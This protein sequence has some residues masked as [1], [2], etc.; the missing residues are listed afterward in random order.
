[1]FSLP[2]WLHN[3]CLLFGYMLPELL[4]FLGLQPDS[5]VPLLFGSLYALVFTGITVILPKTIGKAVFTCG[6][7]SMTAWAAAQVIYYNLFHRLLWTADIAFASDGVIFLDDVLNF[8]APPA[9]WLI[10]VLVILFYFILLLGW[11]KESKQSRRSRNYPILITAICLFVLCTLENSKLVSEKNMSQGAFPIYKEYGMYHLFKEDVLT[12]HLERYL[13]GYEQKQRSYCEEIDCYFAK[14]PQPTAN[15]M[16]GALKGKN[17]LIVMMESLDDW[18]ISPEQTPTLCSL[19]EESIVFTDFY[20]PFYGTTRSINTEVSL[21][22]GMYFP[23]NGCYFYDYLDHSFE[24]SLTFLLKEYGYT[25]QI[26]HHNYPEYYRRT[27]LIP[28]IGYDQYNSYISESGQKEVLNDCYPFDSPTMRQQFFR[29]G[30]TFN[31]L[32]TQ[33]AHMPYNYEDSMS[34]YAM[35][36]HPEYYGA[37]GSEEEDCI[38]AKAR[39]VDDMFLRLFHELEKEGTLE[40]TVILALSD[41]YPY[42]Y[43][44]TEQLLAYADHAQ[45]LLLLDNTPCF[46]WSADLEPMTV[47]KTLST[48]DLLPTLLNLLGIP[49]DYHYLGRDAFDPNYEGYAFF[50]DG[51][52]VSDGVVCRNYPAEGVSTIAANKYGR[53][54]NDAWIQN[55]IDESCT[56][57]KISNLLLVSDYYNQKK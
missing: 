43:S 49:Q 19:M 22:T 17:L 12:C 24:Q 29:E 46:L 55:M 39:L 53:T 48:S 3:S 14:R 52:W 25:S 21:N 41:H 31:L 45:D 38:R 7:F 54:L 51:S 33:A 11:P 13:P 30:P 56:F 26:F 47:R 40:D 16:T 34:I 28:A 2:V 44:D 23:T 20:T 35:E 50:P 6:Y 57:T 9:F 32:I 8:Y 42:G 5:V 15:E 37:Y 27:E 36:K 18:M 1:M 10:L 4:M